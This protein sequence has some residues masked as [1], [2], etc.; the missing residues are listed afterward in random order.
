[1][2]DID[3]TPETPVTIPDRLGWW[4]GESK[5]LWL[6]LLEGVTEGLPY[7]TTALSALRGPN[8]S[9][10]DDL[11]KQASFAAYM[12]DVD[13]QLTALDTKLQGVQT[14]LD[15]LL[16]DTGDGVNGYLASK[17]VRGL[18]WQL[19]QYAQQGFSGIPP[20]QQ[21]GDLQSEGSTIIEGRKYATFTPPIAGVDISG[22]GTV[23]T[24]TTA[25]E[26][27]T[28]YIQTTDPAPHL[29]GDE[30]A[31]NAWLPLSG[32]AGVTFS[33]AVQYQ[34]AVFL[35]QPERLGFNWR[36]ILGEIEEVSTTF[37]ARWLPVTTKYPSIVWGDI[38]GGSRMLVGDFSGWQWEVL[39]GGG[40]AQW[41]FGSDWGLSGNDTGTFPNGTISIIVQ[42]SG[43]PGEDASIT[44]VPPGTDLPGHPS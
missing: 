25:W 26:G 39:G 4:R 33:V 27:W 18:L 31:P 44:L 5:A 36:Y 7:I 42:F 10:L 34:I 2:S 32:S 28:Y 43:Y 24:P 3:P 37:G 9:T 1:M 8:A 15:N 41:T 35:R 12:S 14:R 20:T 40:Q 22:G 19:L 13:D 30:V 23:L 17:T 6:R 38:G 16:S 21:D 29:S 11:V